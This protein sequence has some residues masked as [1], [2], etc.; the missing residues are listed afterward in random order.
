MGNDRSVVPIIQELIP[1]T[2]T[3]SGPRP[4][5]NEMKKGIRKEKRKSLGWNALEMLKTT[6]A[7]R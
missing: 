2:G 7:A 3:R 4:N 1:P 6:W 5:K